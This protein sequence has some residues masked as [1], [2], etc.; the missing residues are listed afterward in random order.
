MSAKF[1]VNDKVYLKKDDTSIPTGYSN[2]KNH[3][4]VYIIKDVT[5][6]LVKT[7]TGY[8]VRFYYTLYDRN[9]PSAIST[10][11]TLDDVEESRIYGKAEGGRRL[12]RTRR[13]SKR[14]AGT[15]RRRA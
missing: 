4:N 14:R 10:N 11:K 1:I 9:D 3:T 2:N 15:R 5:K 13:R 12:V 8:D 6:K 7:P